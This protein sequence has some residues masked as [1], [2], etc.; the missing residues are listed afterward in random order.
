MVI[1]LITFFMIGAVIF[2]LF[3]L[4]MP[5]FLSYFWF[6]LGILLVIGIAYLSYQYLKKI[7]HLIYSIKNS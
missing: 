1:R 2:T 6:S 7:I 3:T 4:F 5:D